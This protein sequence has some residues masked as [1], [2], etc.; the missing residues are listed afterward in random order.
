MNKVEMIKT[1]IAEIEARIKRRAEH[2]HFG[3]P[4]FS[5]WYQIQIERIQ[6]LQCELAMSIEEN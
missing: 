6:V 5:E 2:T 4:I 3:D 1:E